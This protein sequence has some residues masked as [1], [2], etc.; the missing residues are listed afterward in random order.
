MRYVHCYW[1]I[2]SFRPS[3]WANLGNNTIHMEF[4]LWCNRIGNVSAAPRHRFN[5]QHSIGSILY[6]HRY[7]IGHNYGLDL[8]PGPGTPY[9]ARWPKKKK[10][11]IYIINTFIS[12]F[13]VYVCVYKCMHIFICISLSEFISSHNLFNALF[14]NHIQI[15][16]I[17]WVYTHDDLLYQLSCTPSLV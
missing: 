2:I 12:I 17:G 1:G 15:C 6:C 5:P 4:L 9:A 11:T 8:L 10:N 16:P 3:Q 13:C 7:S 14:P